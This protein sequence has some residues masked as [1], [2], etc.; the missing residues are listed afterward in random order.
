MRLF[1][2]HTPTLLSHHQ[3]VVVLLGDTDTIEQK[4]F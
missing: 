3:V 4:E 2:T 1:T